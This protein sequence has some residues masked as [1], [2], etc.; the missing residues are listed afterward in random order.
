MGTRAAAASCWT[1]DEEKNESSPRRRLNCGKRKV[2]KDVE[3]KETWTLS[4]FRAGWGCMWGHCVWKQNGLQVKTG[5][6]TQLP[7]I[8]GERRGWKVECHERCREEPRSRLSL[9]NPPYLR[10]MQAIG[11]FSFS[12]FVVL[13]VEGGWI[14]LSGRKWPGEAHAR[15]LCWTGLLAI[16]EAC[17]S[18]RGPRSH[19]QKLYQLPADD[20]A[21]SARN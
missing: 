18:P 1:L 6:P 16:S 3:C 4:T 2:V 21:S 7:S 15:A 9:W 12:G 20:T 19:Q 11:I 10:N 17:V 5:P 13:L 14:L 8:I